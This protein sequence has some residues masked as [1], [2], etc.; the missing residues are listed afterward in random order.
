MVSGMWGLEL[1]NERLRV[2]R[3]A[4]EDTSGVPFSRMQKVHVPRW[5]TMLGMAMILSWNK[6]VAMVAKTHH[7]IVS[8]LPS[9]PLI[10]G[11]MRP[12]IPEFQLSYNMWLILW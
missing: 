5:E 9:L 2:G 8:H 7:N 10:G 4:T 11:T 6:V 12:W 3:G 1:E